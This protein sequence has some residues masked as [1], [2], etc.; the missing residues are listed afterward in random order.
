MLTVVKPA[1][2]GGEGMAVPSWLPCLHCL[3][4][5]CAMLGFWV[6]T[7][8]PSHTQIGFMYI[9]ACVLVML[10]IGGEG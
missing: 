5:G 6:A 2:T 1:V 8:C 4:A 9:T 10:C 7:A 3:S